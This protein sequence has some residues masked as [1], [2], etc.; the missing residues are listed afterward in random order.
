M[1]GL[2]NI[3]WLSFTLLILVYGVFGWIY[4]SWAIEWIEE[5]KLFGWV[6]EEN[7]ATG[8]IYGIGVVWVLIV[9]TAFTIP[10]TLMSNLNS[11]LNPGARA[12]ISIVLGA[13][14]VALIFH[15]LVLFTRFFVLLA[16]ALFAKIDLQ[17]LGCDRW[18]S[19][20]ILGLLSL[21]AFIAGVIG[22]YIRV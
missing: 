8:F 2:K 3:P 11:W 18:L 1:F 6:L 4:A 10:A 12:F 7:I 21:T 16:A 9:A 15:W 17:V 5:G 19:A 13:L 14:I 22:F 20:L